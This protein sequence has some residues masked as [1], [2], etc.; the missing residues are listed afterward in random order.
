MTDR[1]AGPAR[2][3]RRQGEALPAAPETEAPGTAAPAALSAARTPAAAAAPAAPGSAAVPARLATLQ[4]RIRSHIWLAALLAGVAAIAVYYTPLF[5]ANSRAVAYIVIEALAVL[6]VFATLYFRRPAR[7]LAWAL[8]GA[9]MASV[10]LGDVVW[11]WIVQVEQV[12]PS[13][14]LADVFYIAEYPL[15]IAGVLTLVRG[16]PDRA[17]IL[18]TLIVTTA[19][20]LVVIEFLVQPDLE[21]YT[22][23][24]LDLVVMLIYPIADVALLAVALRSLLAGDLHS[25]VL[26]LL[27]AGIVAV[28]FA[29]IL[30]LRLSLTDLAPDPSPL[31]S[32]WLISMIMW[33]AA[34]MHPAART[35][36]A[37]VGVDWMRQRTARR[38]LLTAALLIPPVTLAIQASS[39][40]TTYTLVSMAAWG[41]I[42]LFVMMRTDVAMSQARESEARMQ[43]ITDSAHD[44][45]AMMDPEGRVSYWNP[46]AERMFGHT[47]AEAIGQYLHTFLAPSR[48]VDRFRSAFSSFLETGTGAAMGKPIDLEGRRGDGREFPVQLS[49]SAVR[50][51]G[52]WHAVGVLRDVTEQKRAQEALRDSEEKHRLLIENSQDIIYTL[53]SDAIFTFVSPA[54]TMLLGHVEAQVVGQPLGRFVH[55]G[56]LGCYLEFLSSIAQGSCAQDSV[57]YRVQD[58]YGEWFWHASSA[59]PLRDAAGTVVGFEGIARDITAQKKAEDA[60]ERFRIGFEQ[61]AVGQSLTSLDGRFMQVNDALAGMLGYAA[62]ELAGRRMDELTHP[63]YVS[64]SAAAQTELIARKGARRFESRYITQTGDLVWADVNVALV[65]NGKGE[66]DYFVET[67]VDVTARKEAEEELTATNVALGQAMTRAIE[68]AAEADTANQAKSEFLANMSH[69]I[70]TPMNGVIGMT[71]LLLDTSLDSDQRRYA[72]VV[73]TSA[74]SLLAI[75]NDILDFSKIEAGKL[76]LETLDFDLRS[77]LNDFAALLA[78]RAQKADLEFICAAAPDVPGHLSGDPGRLRQILLNLAGNAVKFTHH[79][80]VAVRVALEWE[81]DSDVMLRFSVKDTGIGIPADKQP[82]LFQKFTQADASTSRKYGGTGLGLAI[83]KELAELMGGEIGLISREGEG[84]EFWFTAQLAK[85]AT[86][87]NAALPPARLDGVRILVVDDNASS[88]EVLTSQLTAWG[89]RSDEAADGET[90]LRFLRLARDQNDPYAA[91]IVDMQMPGMAGS[92]LAR[93]IKADETLAPIR[94]V[95]M[96]ALGARGNTDEL[97]YIEAAYLSKPVRQSDF[98]DCLAAVVAGQAAPGVAQAPVGDDAAQGLAA[99]G[100]ARILLAEDNTTNQL[101]ALGILHKLGMHADAVANGVEAVRSLEAIPYDLVLMDVQMPEMDGLEAT[102]RIRDPQSS[103]KNRAI[104]IVA[105]TANALQGDRERCLEAGMNGYVTKPVSPSALAEAL[106]RW[107]PRDGAGRLEPGAESVAAAGPPPQSA[108]SAPPAVFDRTGMLAR[109]MGDEELGQIVIEG[110]LGEMPDRIEALRSCLAAGDAAGSLR[111]VHTIK[112]AS[113]NVGGEALRAVALAAEQAGQGGNLA[114]IITRVPEIELQFALLKEAM[115]GV[116]GPEGAAPGERS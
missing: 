85:Q 8:F 62:D 112:G 116:A 66:P 69:E 53:T 55:P 28:V 54:W 34:A 45:I 48:Y 105:M 86:R 43:A 10:M 39:G 98:F 16:R 29:D 20:L 99:R 78:V 89:V 30:N 21:G 108:E 58:L 24:T 82:A 11:L 41:V 104:P 12:Q 17:T 52:R 91:A 74:E 80:E 79:G 77:L 36:L 51:H 42:A 50:L 33:A 46:A 107:L 93:A 6:G 60:I 59:V 5:D 88:R 110:F 100:R 68:L 106:D 26:R 115:L 4:G 19:A 25:P 2:D 7:P 97:A 47:R 111:E 84:S 49:L 18:D 73:R 22:G 1:S 31:D 61:G 67:F 35:A 63:D 102:R 37:E 96:T 71:G 9:G 44:A 92:D 109:L 15:L 114:V 76:G 14:S 38:V 32:L 103:V 87:E 64:A 3:R 83:S 75:L 72:E 81:T 94:L 56:D 113:A 23:S 70:R 57:E 95:L 65:C 90:A 27:L 101:V 40:A 13:T